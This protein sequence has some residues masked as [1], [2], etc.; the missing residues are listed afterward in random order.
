M[1]K[2]INIVILDRLTLGN[3]IDLSKFSDIGNVTV[4]D[5]STVSEAKH[6]LVDA[7]IVIVNK[8]PM[9]SE[10]LS[11]AKNLKL[12]AITATGYN[13]I[14][15]SYTNAN[16]I[17]VTNVA[18]YSTNSV[19]QHTFALL[20]YVLEKLNYYDTYVKSGEY[21]KSSIFCNLDEIFPE[22]FQK[23]W[24]IIG[25][26]EI[27][28][29]VASIAK[30]FGCNVIYYSTSGRNNNPDY[31]QVSFDE[32]LSASDIISVH[33]PLNSA[34]ENLINYEAFS[35]MKKSAVFLNLG[36]GPIVNEAD[37]AKALNENL[38]CA[39]GL[40]V[41]TKEPMSADN[42]LLQIKDSRKLL[43]TPHI[44]WATYEARTRL[45]EL[46]YENIT[47]FLKGNPQ[48]VINPN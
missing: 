5:T 41:L 18:G 37:L 47:A 36:R 2:D 11:L 34:T 27:G 28:R 7:D 22:I 17:T 46:V 1:D 4:Y 26:G 8:V 19:V 10:T 23:T 31:T 21:S 16:N 20:F 29:S 48:N 30:A 32:L 13:N 38:I 9:N 14:D 39:A 3:D 40:D 35:K 24:G 12:I 33:A 6:R 25:L 42:P 43:I 15:F 44:A 45:I